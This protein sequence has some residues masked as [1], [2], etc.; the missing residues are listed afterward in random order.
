[1]AMMSSFTGKSPSSESGLTD[2]FENKKTEEQKMIY[3]WEEYPQISQGFQEPTRSGQ[4]NLNQC[5]REGDYI[6]V[7]NGDHIRIEK[8]VHRHMKPVLLIC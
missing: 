4:I 7:E 5:P 1:M 2:S 8:V 3:D 6:E